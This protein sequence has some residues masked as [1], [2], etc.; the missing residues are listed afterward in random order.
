M[1]ARR[2]IPDPDPGASGRTADWSAAD[3]GAVRAADKRFVWHPFTQMRGF[4]GE[5]AP[6]IESGDREWLVGTEGRRCID[7]MPKDRR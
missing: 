1:I 4:E 3:T 2:V 6:V 7:G 5:D